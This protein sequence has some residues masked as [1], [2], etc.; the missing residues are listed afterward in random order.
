MSDRDNNRRLLPDATFTQV[1]GAGHSLT[2][3]KPEVVAAL[4][5]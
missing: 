1:P 2:L 5:R 3:E 4:V